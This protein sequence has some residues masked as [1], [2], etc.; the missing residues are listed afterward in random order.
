MSDTF[1]T[2]KIFKSSTYFILSVEMV[3]RRSYFQ[4]N[5]KKIY[6]IFLCKCK[7]GNTKP[8]THCLPLLI[9]WRQKRSRRIPVKFLQEKDKA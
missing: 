1:W 5:I 2:N 6:S 4:K 3:S 8:A 7:S 9:N